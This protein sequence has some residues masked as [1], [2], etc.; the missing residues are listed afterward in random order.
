VLFKRHISF[1]I[2]GLFM[3]AAF[4]L[5]PLA[6]RVEGQ[7]FPV[8]TDVRI[9][10]TERTGTTW[11]RFWGGFDKVRDCDFVRIDWALQIGENYAVADFRFDEGPKIR[12]EGGED[13]GPWAVQLSTEQLQERGYAVVFHRC[14]P[15][16]L[17]ETLFYK[18]PVATGPLFAPYGA[19]K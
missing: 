13:F 14:H 16:W 12:Y 4:Y 17:T 5:T 11:T 9:T 6:G 19:L 15:F 8:A 10:A 7:L 18:G 3:L 1:L 2:G